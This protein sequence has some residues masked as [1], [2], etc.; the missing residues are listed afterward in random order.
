MPLQARPMKHILI[1][2]MALIKVR[3]IVE[4]LGYIC[5][6]LHW[7]Q[8]PIDSIPQFELQSQTFLALTASHN[9]QFVKSYNLSMS[10]S[11]KQVIWLQL[12]TEF[13]F[14]THCLPQF[15]SSASYSCPPAMPRH[16]TSPAAQRPHTAQVS[17]PAAMS[18]RRCP[19]WGTW[20]QMGT[21]DS[22]LVE[23]PHCWCWSRNAALWVLHSL[24]M[25][26]LW[27]FS[28]D[29]KTSRLKLTLY[30]HKTMFI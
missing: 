28:V 29:N 18:Q 19:H 2:S 16:A 11:K 14:L 26:S 27:E 3:K 30:K 13:Q 22:L 12:R 21:W 17:Y 24:Q 15:H 1:N 20:R 10:H 25:G 5:R 9:T 6:S 4:T 8:F 23:V 7:F